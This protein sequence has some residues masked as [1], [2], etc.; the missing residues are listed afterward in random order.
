MALRLSA[1]PIA[2]TAA[3]N[4]PR[5]ISVLPRTHTSQQAGRSIDDFAAPSGQKVGRKGLI[6]LNNGGVHAGSPK[7][8]MLLRRQNRIRWRHHKRPSSGRAHAGG[9]FMTRIAAI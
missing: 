2:V 6:F 7:T 8:A 4:V 9:I 1:P 3:A 5:V